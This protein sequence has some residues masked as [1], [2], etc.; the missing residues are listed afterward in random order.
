LQEN[1]NL[2]YANATSIERP[3]LCLLEEILPYQHYPAH[4][5]IDFVY[6]AKPLQ[7][8][9]PASHHLQWFTWEDLQLLKAEV[10]IFEETKKV[11]H[12]LFLNH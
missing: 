11:I 4:Q 8:L 2:S 10:D 12:H 7:Q 6:V 5:H 9:G 1:L 3:Y